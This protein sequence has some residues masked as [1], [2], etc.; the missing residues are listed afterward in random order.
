MEKSHEYT[1]QVEEDFTY[2]LDYILQ[3]EKHSKKLFKFSK[4]TFDDLASHFIKL[5]KN[6]NL[7]IDT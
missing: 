6:N 1:V 7:K 5:I 3:I 4:I 2:I